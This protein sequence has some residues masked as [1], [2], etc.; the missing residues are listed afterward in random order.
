MGASIEPADVTASCVTIKTCLELARGSLA[1]KSS[2][3]DKAR[4]ACGELFRPS[5]SS[6][7]TLEAAG[8]TASDSLGVAFAFI[9]RAASNSVTKRAASNSSQKVARSSANFRCCSSSCRRCSETASKAVSS[10]VRKSLVSR[11]IFSMSSFSTTE[12]C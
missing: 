1:A 8:A 9:E 2:V 4:N 11:V 3:D 7:E 12:S 5:S 6:L 10:L